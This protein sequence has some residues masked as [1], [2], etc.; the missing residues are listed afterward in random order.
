L[1]QQPPSRS[2]PASGHS[3]VMTVGLA[4]LLAATASVAASAAAAPRSPPRCAT[5]DLLAPRAVE[6]AASEPECPQSVL[7][8]EA[9]HLQ[10]RG[11]VEGLSEGHLP[12]Q[13][14]PPRMPR[15]PQTRLPGCKLPKP[16]KPPLSSRR[17]PS[18]GCTD[19]IDLDFPIRP[20]RTSRFLQDFRSQSYTHLLTLPPDYNGTTPVRLQMH[21]HGWGARAR[22]CG[23]PCFNLAPEVNFASIALQGIGPSRRASWNGSGT[24]ASPDALGRPTCEPDARDYCYDDCGE[25][26]DGC[27][28]TTCED[29]VLQVYEVLE[30]LKNSLCLELK[31]I[32]ATG[33]SNG[34]IFLHELARDPRIAPQLAGIAPI[35]GLPHRGFN[36]Q[37]LFN[38]SY[39]G[40][41]G[42]DDTVVPP[43]SNTEDS[44]VSVSTSALVLSGWFYQ[45]STSVRNNWGE[46]LKC[47]TAAPFLT[48]E[49]SIGDQ[50]DG[51]ACTTFQCPNQSIDI[52]ECRANVGHTC[53]RES[54]WVPIFEFMLAHPKLA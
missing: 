35:V 23:D 47:N 53:S 29:S 39:I 13:W 24:V 40:M 42:N 14:V 38:M 12:P 32:W 28:W 25:R 6:A 37:P 54:Q 22:Q 21:F 9:S 27:W 41:F 4:A 30:K 44:D 49:W 17:R 7:G 31:E 11:E 8:D 3:R 5:A 50:S 20:G 45:T 2:M 18:R 15:L 1:P 33:C 43:L 51:L 36:F 48:D 26:C 52:V 19:P 46:A 10:F 16:D 34:G